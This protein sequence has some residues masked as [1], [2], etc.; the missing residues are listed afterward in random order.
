MLV[1]FLLLIG[2]TIQNHDFLFSSTC[3]V[4]CNMTILII[5]DASVLLATSMIQFVLHR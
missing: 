3:T 4:G 2:F 1:S 5:A